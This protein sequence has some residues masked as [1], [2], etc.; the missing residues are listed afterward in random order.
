MV[1]SDFP[2]PEIACCQGPECSSSRCPGSTGRERGE[3]GF[4]AESPC[5][6]DGRCPTRPSVPRS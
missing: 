1:Y 5:P 6:S 2:D 3:R 4:V